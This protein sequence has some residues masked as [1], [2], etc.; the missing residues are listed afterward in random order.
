M[1]IKILKS[2]RYPGETLIEGEIKDVSDEFAKQL[3]A[4]KKAVIADD[5]VDIYIDLA[6][7]LS[8]LKKDE[9]VAYAVEHDIY[10]DG[11]KTKE[12]ILDAIETQE[13]E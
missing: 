4:M 12:Q 11:L 10:I 7:D 1:K 9:L 8:K 6:L 3:I 2:T 13:G 5:Q